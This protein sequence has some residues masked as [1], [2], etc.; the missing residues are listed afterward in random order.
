MELHVKLN[1]NLNENLM[2]MKKKTIDMIYAFWKNVKK[3]LKIWKKNKSSG[4]DGIPVEFYKLFWN[5]LKTYLCDALLYSLQW[6][7][8]QLH[9]KC[10]YICN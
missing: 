4:I 7:S 6:T 9:I 10:Q 2:I 5:E 1:E 3:Q 8:L